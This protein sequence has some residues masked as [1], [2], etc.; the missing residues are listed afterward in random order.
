ME[1]WS[2]SV[3][4]VHANVDALRQ[5]M[6]NALSH[7][8]W[9]TDAADT[10]DFALRKAVSSAPSTTNKSPSKV[11]STATATTPRRASKTPR[12][13]TGSA[14]K[15]ISTTKRIVYKTAE[16]LSAVYNEFLFG[17]VCGDVSL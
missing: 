17:N 14:R 13:K 6:E 9:S 10:V 7:V 2:E 16:A 15:A 4:H 12:S 3:P 1:S 8:D 11:N 5:Q